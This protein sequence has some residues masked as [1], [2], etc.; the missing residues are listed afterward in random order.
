MRRKLKG[1]SEL[2]CFRS[3]KRAL[4]QKCALYDGI[5]IN[6]KSSTIKQVGL[7]HPGLCQ[8]FHCGISGN[9]VKDENI[10]NNL[11]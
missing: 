6:F 1:Y 3:Q 11:F 8:L 9:I 5:K 4:V 2:Q 10:C 7:S